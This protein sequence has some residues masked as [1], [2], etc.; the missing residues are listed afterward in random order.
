MLG[1]NLYL[2]HILNIYD[3]DILTSRVL[4]AFCR[5]AR[6]KIFNMFNILLA[7]VTIMLMVLYCV[8]TYSED[9]PGDTNPTL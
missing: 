6:S 4:I 3:R 8:P 9:T 1:A 5:L 2:V 7:G